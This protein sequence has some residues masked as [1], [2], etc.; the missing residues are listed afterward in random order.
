MILRSYPNVD[1][2]EYQR[3]R[4]ERKHRRRK[5]FAMLIASL[6]KTTIRYGLS[7]G[8]LEKISNYS[9]Q[10]GFK[11]KSQEVMEALLNKV[12][13]ESLTCDY[14][15]VIIPSL[16]R[17]ATYESEQKPIQS[18]IENLLHSQAEAIAAQQ[19]SKSI[20]LSLIFKSHP[21]MLARVLGMSGKFK[22]FPAEALFALLRQFSAGM[23]LLGDHE[24]G[25]QFLDRILIA[26]LASWVAFS[27][28][29]IFYEK[30]ALIFVRP[31]AILNAI[32]QTVALILAYGTS[33]SFYEIAKRS[34]IEH[35]VNLD[36]RDPTHWTEM[37]WLLSPIVVEVCFVLSWQLQY[38]PYVEGVN[39]I[40]VWISTIIGSALGASTL[41]FWARSIAPKVRE[42][43]QHR[44]QEFEAKAAERAL[45]RAQE[46]RERDLVLEGELEHFRDA[47]KQVGG[48]ALQLKAAMQE[49]KT[50]QGLFK[51]ERKNHAS[52]VSRWRMQIRFK[53]I[54]LE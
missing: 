29:P 22:K 26:F 38:R 42:Y 41:A 47:S 15:H 48:S 31:N 33:W 3:R 51:S 23:S 43:R 28:Q 10:L 25:E 35:F 36:P 50:I 9:P 40:F 32:L 14:Y 7:F 13:D 44:R 21:L 17:L 20:A 24:P 52:F 49:L 53:L 39:P 34:I 46:K 4:K 12:A 5:A 54:D 8:E 27:M 19:A 2:G 37:M 30:L 6:E 18:R 16:E 11:E 1:N 45:E